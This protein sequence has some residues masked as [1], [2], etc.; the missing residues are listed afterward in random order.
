MINNIAAIDPSVADSV[1]N[2]T[3]SVMSYFSSMQINNMMMIISKIY[4]INK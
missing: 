2:I 4:S 1:A 3:V